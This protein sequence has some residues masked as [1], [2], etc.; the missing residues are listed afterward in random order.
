MND[1]SH[2]GGLG[3]KLLK[4]DTTMVD[5]SR[6]QPVLEIAPELF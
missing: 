4:M 5:L 2:L 1:Y 6:G 3:Q